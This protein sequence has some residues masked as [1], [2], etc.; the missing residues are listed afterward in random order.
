VSQNSTGSVRIVDKDG[1]DPK[2][3][4]LSEREW[5]WTSSPVDSIPAARGP[6]GAGGDLIQ[7]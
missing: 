5:S 2:I 4:D 7:Q 3:V 1:E 6:I